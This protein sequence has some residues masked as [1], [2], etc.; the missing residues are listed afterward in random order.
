MI[1]L[2]YFVSPNARKIHMALEELGL[3]YEIRWVDITKGEQFDP[4][5]LAVN[6]NGKIPA[7][8][9]HDGLGGGG[10]VALFES[11]AILLYLAEKTGRLL[12]ADPAAR[13]EAICWTVWQVANQGP[14]LGQAGHFTTYAPNAGVVHDYAQ[15]RFGAEAQRVYQVLED[16]LTGREYLAGDEFSIADIA[17]FPWTRLGKGHGIS[18][19]DYPAVAAWS[20]RI[21]ARPCAKAKAQDLRDGCVKNFQY[22]PEQWRTLFRVTPE[23]ER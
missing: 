18:L 8:V 12:P 9:D 10:P 11:A 5:F 2:F 20:E 16:R 21:S 19:S 6:P 22:T 15:R 23:P 14:G 1:E 17:C 13:W 4:G 7:I 3:P